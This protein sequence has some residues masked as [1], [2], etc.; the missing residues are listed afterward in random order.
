MTYS[1]KKKKA[2]QNKYNAYIPLTTRSFFTWTV[3][4]R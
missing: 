1:K 4:G 2:A 3:W